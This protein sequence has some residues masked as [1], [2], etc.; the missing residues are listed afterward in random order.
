MA[1]TNTFLVNASTRHAIFVN[2]FSGSQLKQM[3]PYLQRVKKSTAAELSGGD[4]TEFSKKRLTKLYNEIEST[5]QAV[6]DKMSG[7]LK[8]NLA[9][10]SA[11]EA[12]FSAT[13]FKKATN[14]DFDIPSKNQIAAAVFA[15]PILTLEDKGLTIDDVLGQF[16]Q[17]KAAQVVNTIQDGVIAGQANSEIINSM[18]KVVDIA[19]ADGLRALVQTVT[20]HT[21]SVSRQQVYDENEDII[22]GYQWVSTLDGRTTETCIALDGQ[23]FDVGEGP[24]P[25]AHWNCRSTTIPVVKKKYS[26]LGLANTQRPAVGNDGPEQDISAKT[27]YGTWLASQPASFQDEVLGKTKGELFRNGGLSVDKFVDHNYQPYTL[28]QLRQRESQAFEKAGLTDDE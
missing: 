28:D 5:I 6:L 9:P 4:L 10:F 20:N 2:R 24:M 15:E 27:D 23:I 7:K 22:D 18:N 26:I 8:S 1:G 3:L 16:N 11:Y 13:M 21:S 17:K 14:V 12:Q 19:M 25:P